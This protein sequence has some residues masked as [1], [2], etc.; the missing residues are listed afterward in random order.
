MRL[1]WF[2]F[3]T[4]WIPSVLPATWHFVAA[5]R[6]LCRGAVTH[7]GEVETF[8]GG[9]GDKHPVLFAAFNTRHKTLGS[10]WPLVD[11]LRGIG[12]PGLKKKKKEERKKEK[13]T[14]VLQVAHSMMWGQ[15]SRADVSSVMM[16]LLNLLPS[17]GMKCSDSALRYNGLHI[18]YLAS[19]ALKVR[20][21]VCVI[22][23]SL[24]TPVLLSF[25]HGDLI[26]SASSKRSFTRSSDR[27]SQC[28]K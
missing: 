22:E 15:I 27:W 2:F 11:S 7:P 21:H 18:L 9:S 10:S 16:A 13:E 25:N 3:L 28:R 17:G 5:L 12:P 23:S 6:A 19:H 8:W 4:Q 26:R 14:T 1:F 24:L 20:Q